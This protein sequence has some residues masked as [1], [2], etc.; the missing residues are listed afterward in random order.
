MSSPLQSLASQIT[1]SF[2]D[3]FAQA[4]AKTGG[5]RPDD[6]TYDCIAEAVNVNDDLTFGTTAERDG[7]QVPAFGVSLTWRMTNDPSSPDEPRSFR[8]RMEVFPK[9]VSQVRDPKRLSSLKTKMGV[10][11]GTLQTI[12][13]HDVADLVQG[14]LELEQAIAASTAEGG[15]AIVC[16]VQV[17]TKGDYVNY[18]VNQRRS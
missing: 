13:G 18:Y 12:L 4:E 3:A 14:L 1:S 17:K 5:W 2:T 8:S 15:V 6:G 16:Q 10:F 9:D 7:P 11:K